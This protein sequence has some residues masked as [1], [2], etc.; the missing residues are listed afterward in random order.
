MKHIVPLPPLEVLQ[1]F[2]TYDPLTGILA[3]KPGLPYAKQR[4]AGKA[5][6]TMSKGGYLRTSISRRMYS[7]NRIAWK[8]HYGTDPVGVVDHED[9]DKLNNKIANLRDASQGKNTYNQVRRTDN[10][11]GYKGV[12]FSKRRG[13]F[14]VNLKVRGVKIKS[15]QFNTPE[16]ANDFVRAERE[17]LHGEFTCHGDRD[18]A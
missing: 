4:Q 3:W 8:M 2:L 9:G 13:V 5:A 1:T 16:A 18:A 7:N 17:R 11:T 12:V 15:P 14:V 10:T 6:G